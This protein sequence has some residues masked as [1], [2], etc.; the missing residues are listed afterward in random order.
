MKKKKRRKRVEKEDVLSES[1]YC[2]LL[3]VTRFICFKP[4]YDGEVESH[5]DSRTRFTSTE[6]MMIESIY[7]KSIGIKIMSNTQ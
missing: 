2:S 1:S 7:K 6:S 4:D 3:G 5:S